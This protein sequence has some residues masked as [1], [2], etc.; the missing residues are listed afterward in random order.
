MRSRDKKT[1]FKC[2][3]IAAWDREQEYLRREHRAGWELE[4]IDFANL[5]RFRRCEPADVVYQLDYN[6]EGLAHADEYVQMFADLGWEHVLDYAGY[7]YFRKPVAQMCAADEE[8]FCDDASRLELLRRVFVGRMVPA[9]VI[10]VALEVPLVVQ[11]AV[12]R[13]TDLVAL[14]VALVLMLVVYA[15]VFVQ[16]AVRYLR[17]RGAA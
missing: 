5:Y 9:L 15:V 16:F 12:E 13:S 8:I 4:R 17:L 14:G 7:S 1:T 3:T 10:V 2:F 11:A 6:P